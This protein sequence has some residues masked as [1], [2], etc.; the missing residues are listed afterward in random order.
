LHVHGTLQVQASLS[1]PLIRQGSSAAIDQR[2][3]T[4]KLTTITRHDDTE[5]IILFDIATS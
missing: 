5:I 4:I 1:A 3:A 2:R